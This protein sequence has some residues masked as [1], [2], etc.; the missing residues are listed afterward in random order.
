[1]RL[2]IQYPFFVFLKYRWSSGTPL[3][4]VEVIYF[5]TCQLGLVTMHPWRAGRACSD[6]NRKQAPI[7]PFPLICGYRQF[8][9]ASAQ[10]VTQFWIRTSIIDT[11][12]IPKINDACSYLPLCRSRLVT[13]GPNWFQSCRICNREG[14][15]KLLSR[16]MESNLPPTSGPPTNARSTL[17]GSSAFRLEGIRQTRP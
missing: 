9:T 16:K 2:L 3:F 4:Q 14:S 15:R 13:K 6:S 12:V 7:L 1:M 10:L 11:A 17:S 5:H 8:I